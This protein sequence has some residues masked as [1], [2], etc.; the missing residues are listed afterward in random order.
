MK[1]QRLGFVLAGVGMVVAT[2]TT[3]A[4]AT[5]S[6]TAAAAA[7]SVQCQQ[8]VV[9]PTISNLVDT[10]DVTA[11]KPPAVLPPYVYSKFFASRFMDRWY[12]A[13][14]ASNTQ[15]YAFGLFLQGS[16]LYRQTTV[17]N[18]SSPAQSKAVRVGTG[19]AS[20]KSIVTSNYPLKGSRPA[21]LYGLNTNGNLYR[22]APNGTGYKAAGSFAGFKSFK[23]MA[24]ISEERTYDTLLMT[25]KAGA[26]YTIHIPTTAKAKPV[27]KLIRKSGWAAYE[28]LVVGK[29]G[30]NGTS[31]DVIGVDHDT[32]A[33][34]QYV[35][36]KFK[37]A[38]T[39]ITSNG[40]VPASFNGINH[41][42]AVGFQA[43]LLAE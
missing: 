16:N 6:G 17:L 21:Y 26:L 33:G 10:V 23:T 9:W 40:K 14:N 12:L 36:T 1:L 38:A 22:Y 18:G 35:F 34:Y 11:A 41:T 3:S 29:C 7:A 15:Y 43:I 27:V 19:W 39:G 2:A 8:S 24:V 25:T 32:N 4:T 37:G 28:S 42:A 5:S 13:W 31:T 30:L 20:F